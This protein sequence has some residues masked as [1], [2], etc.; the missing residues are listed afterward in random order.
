MFLM[1]LVLA[2][3][4]SASHI[5]EFYR[6]IHD[7]TFPHPDLFDAKAIATKIKDNRLVIVVAATGNQIL[8]C[9]VGFPHS[10]NQTFEIGALSVAQVEDRNDIGNGL[11]EALR[12]L[13]V[14]NHGLSYFLAPDEPS[15]RRA[16]QLGAVCWG[17]R[18]AAG[19]HPLSE[20]SLLLGFIGE[21]FDERRVRPPKNAL[22]E[23]VFAKRIL[24]ILKARV[25]DIAPPKNFPVGSPM[26]TGVQVISGRIWPTFYRRENFVVVENTA[27][28]YP[29][30]VIGEFKDKLEKKGVTDVRLTIPVNH[31]EAMG[32]LAA[33]GFTP[34]SYLPGW[35]LRDHHR[36]DCIEMIANLPPRPG[37]S[38]GFISRATGRILDELPCASTSII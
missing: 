23:T 31:L 38:E 24:S 17:F 27:G 18:P 9:G 25:T 14:K 30:E 29:V 15:F 36:F 6:S 8:G 26:G 10:W 34:V 1:K 35:F 16:R 21:N 5:A 28:R 33:M 2:K 19:D 32:E 22:T 4:E 11:F 12:R 13:A 20:A 7:D 3:P 37:P